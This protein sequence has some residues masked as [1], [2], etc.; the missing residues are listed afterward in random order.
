MME[1]DKIKRRMEKVVRRNSKKNGEVSEVSE[2]KRDK[3]EKK[4]TKQG[5][6]L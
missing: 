2:E 1:V 5:L 3:D 4:E 6:S